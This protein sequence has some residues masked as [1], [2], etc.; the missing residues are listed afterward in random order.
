MPRHGIRVYPNPTTDNLTFDWA[1]TGAAAKR[2]LL[3]NSLGLTLKDIALSSGGDTHTLSVRDVPPGI[4]FW[5][6]FAADGR[7]VGAGKIIKE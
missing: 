4:Y 6:L 7:Q 1:T 2:L 5:V 3:C